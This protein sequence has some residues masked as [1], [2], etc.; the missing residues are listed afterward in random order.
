MIKVAGRD[1]LVLFQAFQRRVLTFS[2]E[3]AEGWKV[4]MG[5]V[6][7]QYYRW[8][9]ESPGAVCP[10]VPVRGFGKVWAEHRNVQ[11][12]VGCPLAYPPFD[13]EVA[14]QTAYQPFENGY[15]LLVD[16]GNDRNFGGRGYYAQRIIL[17]FFNEGTF[18]LFEDTWAEGQPVSGGLTPPAGRFEPQKSFGKVWREGTGARVRERLGWAT[19]RE[20]AGPGAYQRF[21][22]GEMY[23]TG[24]SRKIFVLYGFG[25]AYPYPVPTQTPGGA[26]PYRYEVFDDTFTP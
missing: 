16:R 26:I 9:Y 6:G 8:R 3:N 22:K 5:N 25:A 23:W 13:Q 7:A 18:T 21:D 4:E 20:N 19:A 12:G 2:P 10:R 11:R 15:M 14:V 1:R 17:V 24:V